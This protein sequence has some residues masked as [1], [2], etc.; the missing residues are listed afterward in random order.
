MEVGPFSSRTLLQILKKGYKMK[1][2]KYHTIIRT[3]PK[4]NRKIVES[5]KIETPKTN[6]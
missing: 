4:S 3:V 2:N 6:T 5:G 1:K